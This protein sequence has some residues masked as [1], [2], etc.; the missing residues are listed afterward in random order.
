[1]SRKLKARLHF[2]TGSRGIGCCNRQA[3]AATERSGHHIHERCRCGCVGRLAIEGVAKG[4]SQFRRTPLTTT[5]SKRGRKDSGEFGRLDV[6]VKQCR[7]ANSQEGWKGGFEET[8]WRSWD[9]LIASTYAAYSRYAGGAED[10]K[11]VASLIMIGW[12]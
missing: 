2:I 5:P 3:L 8:R 12:S 11:S 4:D 9:R 7:S 6:L 1:M 10:M